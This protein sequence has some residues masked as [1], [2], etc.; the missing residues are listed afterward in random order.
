MK[1]QT[2]AP[3]GES[4]VAIGRAQTSARKDGRAQEEVLASPINCAKYENCL[5]VAGTIANADSTP[6][7]MQVLLSALDFMEPT[8]HE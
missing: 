5:G 7:R 3:L 4:R 6:G 2:M 8:A 1:P